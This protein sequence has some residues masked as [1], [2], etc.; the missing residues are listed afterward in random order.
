MS[1]LRPRIVFLIPLL[2]LF[3]LGREW[4]PVGTDC[5]QETVIAKFCWSQLHTPGLG[6]LRIQTSERPNLL[7]SHWQN[8]APSHLHTFPCYVVTCLWSYTG[9]GQGLALCC[10]SNSRKND[11]KTT[12]RYPETSGPCLPPLPSSSHALA[13]HLTDYGP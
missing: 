12:A 9:T 10:W 13:Q 4:W 8:K 7:S 1:R 3:L 6:L 5:A 2:R 11:D